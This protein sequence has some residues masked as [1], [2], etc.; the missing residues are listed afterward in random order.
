MSAVRYCLVD[1]FDTL[2]Q[3]D[4]A[5]HTIELCGSVGVHV[6]DWNR[7]FDLVRTELLD[8]VLPIAEAY[9]SVLRSCF[10]DVDDQTVSALLRLDRELL[11]THARLFDDATPFLRSL[12]QRGV[13]TAIVSNCTESTRPVLADLGLLDLVD[14]AVLSCEVGCAKPHPAIFLRALEALGAD[15]SSAVLVDDHPR[16]CASARELGMRTVRIV[17]SHDNFGPSDVPTAADL[18]RAESLIWGA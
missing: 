16:Y 6:D 7:A 17:R 11:L 14:V 5:A 8:G 4:L 12:R 1:V 2:L 3:H 13:R 9:S 15:A 18:L 10:P